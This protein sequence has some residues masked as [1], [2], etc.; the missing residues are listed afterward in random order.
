MGFRLSSPPPGDIRAWCTVRDRR[1]G[2]RPRQARWP[3]GAGGARPHDREAW[4]M[5]VVRVERPTAGRRVVPDRGAVAA[6]A[7]GAF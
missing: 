4:R 7:R 3:G 5:R 2:P 1:A 6:R